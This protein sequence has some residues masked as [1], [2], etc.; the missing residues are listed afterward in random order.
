MP[1]DLYTYKELRKALQPI[2]VMCNYS[3]NKDNDN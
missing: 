2:L 3:Y 1:G